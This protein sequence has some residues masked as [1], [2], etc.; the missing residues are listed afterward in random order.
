M[1]GYSNTADGYV[2]AFLY[3][4]G[5]MTDLGSNSIAYAINDSGQVVG[6]FAT[7]DFSALHAFLYSAGV[8]TDLGKLAKIQDGIT[9]AGHFPPIAINN[10]G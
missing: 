1:V 3:S 5:V 2:H 9:R 8:M 7:A 10:S 4:A 6:S